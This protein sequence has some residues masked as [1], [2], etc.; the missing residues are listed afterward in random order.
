MTPGNSWGGVI[1]TSFYHLFITVNTPLGAGIVGVP[2]EDPFNPD[3]ETV[4][5]QFATPDCTGPGYMEQGGLKR[6]IDGG[7][8]LA[9]SADYI[10]YAE[11][12]PEVTVTTAST[13]DNE[14][15]I[16]SGHSHQT[17]SAFPLTPVG[18][19]A[20][21]FTPPFHIVTVASQTATV[22]I[23]FG[24]LLGGVM[25]GLGMKVLRNRPTP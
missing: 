7:P 8:R 23:H 15:G 5:I 25:L 10:L 13:I 9:V 16:C 6:G 18:D 4:P 20:A 17:Y 11:A 1:G 22:P 24:W 19:L 21:E 12:G 14:D 2:R 3:W